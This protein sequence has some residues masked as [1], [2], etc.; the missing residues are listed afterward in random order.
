MTR[1]HDIDNLRFS[2]ILLL[3]PFHAAMV[4]DGGEFGGFFVW[5]HKNPFLHAFVTFTFPWFMSLLFVLAGISAH[6]SLR[7]RGTRGFLSERMKKL[8]V[9]LLLG[10]IFLVP[11]QSYIADLFWNNYSGTYWSHLSIF[12]TKNTY[13]T[14]YDGSFTPSHLWFILY[15]FLYSFILIPLK[16]VYCRL[17]RFT[18]RLRISYPILLLLFLPEYLFLPLLN[19]LSKSVGQYLFLF[20]CGYFILYHEKACSETENFRFISLCLFLLSG[21]VYTFLWCRYS[22]MGA[23]MPILYVFFG[24]T[25]ILSILGYASRYFRRRTPLTAVLSEAAFSLYLL[26]MPV[27]VV[28][29]YFWVKLPLSDL[30]LFLLITFSSL[31]VTLLLYLINK[32]VR[33]IFLYRVHKQ[34]N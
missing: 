17:S 33:Q 10:L 19:I 15:L 13:F 9:P 1:R 7:K 23:W 18:N 24:W 29:A 32:T 12:F 34:E 6:Y 11:V 16:T 28:L 5:L 22:Y 26:H 20:L 14:G 31:G 4:F 3:F 30:I 25:G 2:M 8:L 27:E 21:A